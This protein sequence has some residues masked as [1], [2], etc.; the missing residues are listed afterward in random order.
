MRD[1]TQCHPVLQKR[2]KK[3]IAACRK[4]GIIVGI[5]ECLRTV[6]EQDEL[7]AKGRTKP[8]TICTNAKGSTYSSM[9][10]WGIAV[11][12]YLMLMDIDGDGKTSDDAFNDSTGVFEKAGAIAKKYKLEWGGGWTSIKDRPHLQ[13]PE[14]GS[15][16]YKLKQLYGTPQKFMKS[17]TWKK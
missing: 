2:I 5:G 15:T 4:A 3:W 12:F 14:W 10:Q 16:P 1:I 17:K 6:D 7:Y 8:G 13:L 11:D 9:H